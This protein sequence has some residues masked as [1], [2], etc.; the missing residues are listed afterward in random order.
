MEKLVRKD[1]T[2]GAHAV[3][4]AVTARPIMNDVNVMVGREQDQPPTHDRFLCGFDELDER[5]AQI[6]PLRYERSRNHLSGATTWLS[7]FLTHGI[8]DT[9]DIAQAVLSRH[10]RKDCHRLLFEL[11]WRE[12]F[13]RTWQERGDAIFSDLRQPQQGVLEQALPRALIDSTTGILV[14]DDCLRHLQAQGTMHNHARM[15]VASLA[16]NLAGTHW[17]TGARWFHYHL[18]DGDL[19]SNTLSWQWIAGTFSH[20]V[21]L[22]NQHNIDRY[23][24]HMQSGSWLD[25]SHE[26]LNEARE[27]ARVPEVLQPRCSWQSRL[28]DENALPGVPIEHHAGSIALYSPWTMDLRWQPEV[29]HRLLFIDVDLLRQWPLSENRWRFILH[30][31]AMLDA[32]VCHGTVQ[33]LGEALTDASV[34]R[35]DYPACRDWPGKVRPRR[36]VY[37]RPKAHFNSFSRFWKQVQGSV[38]S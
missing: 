6:D 25:V 23:S 35:I 9:R 26:S 3:C 19:A 1:E 21:Y 16:C 37:P 38:L 32:T 31:A 20:K 24:H 14:V 12:F 10:D 2:D 28:S 34:I 4:T 7:P 29:D 27:Q 15:W 11:A 30:W 8:L 22:A 13:H 33:Q 5:L 36:W 18:L 17:Q